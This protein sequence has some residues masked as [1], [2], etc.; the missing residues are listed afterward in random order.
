MPPRSAAAAK[1]ANLGLIAGATQR[2]ASMVANSDPRTLREI[3]VLAISP[4]PHQPRREF[5]EEELQA[6]AASIEKHGLVQPVC[7][8]EIEPGAFQLIA[9]ERRLRAHRVLER[10][11]ILALVYPPNADPRELALVENAQRSDLSAVELAQSLQQLHDERNVSHEALGRIIGKTQS[12]VTRLLSIC[13]LSKDILDEAG[14]YPEVGVSHLWI[15]AEAEPNM[16]SALWE[17]AKSGESIRALKEARSAAALLDGDDGQEP[18]SPPRSRSATNPF[19]RAL[20]TAEAALS[21]MRK[22][23]DGGGTLSPDDQ[24]SLRALRSRIDDLLG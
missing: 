11:D 10:K 4:N 16:R 24:A 3:P 9:G 20:S 19:Q 23:H 21:R 14:Q 12:Y 8:Q 15:I 1:T 5:R 6:L 13:R 2:V 18:A 7:V 22:M 17:L